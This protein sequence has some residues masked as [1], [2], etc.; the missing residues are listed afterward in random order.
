MCGAGAAEAAEAAPVQ[1]E[2]E[3]KRRDCVAAVHAVHARRSKE[4]QMVLH[5]RNNPLG[6]VRSK[7]ATLQ[8]YV[9]Q[10]ASPRGTSHYELPRPLVPAP[11]GAPVEKAS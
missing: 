8:N 6:G 5:F 9:F 7:A 3:E 4:T 11:H 1:V 2:L 10:R